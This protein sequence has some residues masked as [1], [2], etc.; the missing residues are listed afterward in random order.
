V[1]GDR[2]L[3]FQAISNLVDN[4]V[5]FTPSGGRVRLDV[6]Q[7]SSDALVA[8][9]DSGPG[10]PAEARERVLERFVRLDSSRGAPGSGLGLSLV[11]AVARLHGG[12]IELDDNAPGLRAVLRLPLA[13]PEQAVTPRAADRTAVAPPSRSATVGEGG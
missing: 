10:I 11:A 3:L 6:T 12:A 9:A 7:S 13:A 5:K 1:Q 4:A 2:H 8:V